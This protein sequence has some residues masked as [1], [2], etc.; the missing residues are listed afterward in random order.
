MRRRRD[1]LKVLV[2]LC[3]YVFLTSGLAA[4]DNDAVAAF[5]NLKPSLAIVESVAAGVTSRGTAFCVASNNNRS[6]FLTNNHVLIGDSVKLRLEVDH[7][8]YVAHILRRGAA[9]MDVALIEVARGNIPVVTLAAQ[10]P[11]PGTLIAVAGY[12]S[13]HLTSDLEP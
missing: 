9:P 10:L 6:Y 5:E 13:L 3:V 12:P 7:Q 8:T 4:A 11:E 1:K 2:A